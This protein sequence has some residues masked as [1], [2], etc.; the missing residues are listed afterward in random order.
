MGLIYLYFLIIKL[1]LNLVQAL[2]LCTDLTAH[3]TCTG[4]ALLFI[5][6]GTKRSEGSHSRAGC[7][8]PPGET[9]YPFYIRL[10]R[11]QDPSGR[12]WKISSPP[13][14]D[15]RNFQPLASRYTVFATRPSS[16]N[17]FPSK[18][19]MCYLE[20]FFFFPE[21]QTNARTKLNRH[22]KISC[23]FQ[24]IVFK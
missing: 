13:G 19:I 11:P 2:K 9:R 24:K 20:I 3:R 4:I 15:P 14:F 10:S 23:Y 22:Q 12:V 18:L 5:D 16:V 7:S 21:V 17:K 8:L 6:H 1:K